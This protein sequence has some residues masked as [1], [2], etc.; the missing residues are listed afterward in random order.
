MAPPESP[1]HQ[2]PRLCAQT[3]MVNGIKSA[4][5]NFLRSAGAKEAISRTSHVFDPAKQSKRFKLLT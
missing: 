2:L 4:A 1:G 5:S 3:S